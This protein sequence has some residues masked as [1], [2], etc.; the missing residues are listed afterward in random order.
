MFV[1]KMASLS[2]HQRSRMFV[3]KMASLSRLQGSR[4]LV[5]RPL[6]PTFPWFLG[7]ITCLLPATCL[8]PGALI[9]E[10]TI[11]ARQSVVPLAAWRD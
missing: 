4:M 9:R 10:A 11:C 8:S 1:E 7:P 3:E 6:G 5:V 2:R